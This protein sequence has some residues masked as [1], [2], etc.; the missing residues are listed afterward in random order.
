L[1]IT[2]AEPK[3]ARAAQS[4]GFVARAAT[5]IRTS[6]SAFAMT[7]LLGLV[8]L[9]WSRQPLWHTDLWGHLAYGR[10]IVADRVLPATEPLMPLSQGIR[11]TDLAWLSEVLGYLAFQWKGAAAI[12]FAYAASITACLA[13]IAYRTATRTGSVWAAVLAIAAC[14]WLE[15]QQ[16]LIVRPQLAALVCFTCLFALLSAR[17]LRPVCFLVVPILFGL[18]A[19]LHGSFVVGFVMIA[20]FA[21]GRAVDLLR[22]KAPS[23][24]VWRDARFRQILGLLGV[25]VLGTLANPYGWRI[26]QIAWRT[27]GNPNFAELVEWKPLTLEMRQGQAALAVSI[28][29]LVA[30]WRTPRRIAAVE[31]IL[32]VALGLSAMR[33]SRMIVWWAPV[34]ASYLGLHCGAI[35]RRFLTRRSL[36][37]TESRV[38]TS[39]AWTLAGSLMIG[40]VALCSPLG[41]AIVLGKESTP[42]ESYSSQTPLGATAYLNA[43]PPQG[44]VFNTYEWGDYLLWAGQQNLRV[45][46][47]SHAHLVPR[48]VWLDYL[49]VIAVQEGWERILDRYQTSIAVLDPVQHGDLVD[50][51]RESKNWSLVYEDDRSTIF[52]RRYG[53]GPIGG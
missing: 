51:L 17:R 31:F 34:A 42:A 39:L 44:Q 6:R 36:P 41:Q 33:T 30:Y 35:G 22:K 52:V 14:T 46:V 9:Y 7:A 32:L 15:W 43:H 40:V 16:F 48:E 13:V 23:S 5:G 4:S 24:S 2:R 20:G 21:A 45:F 12:Q 27:A 18:W 10:L 1:A 3:A 50:A 19:N 25:A 8:F 11:F 38:R 37:P 53:R 29:L 28:A 26:F 49:R 47:A